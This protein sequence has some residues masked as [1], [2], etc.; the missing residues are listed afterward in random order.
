MSSH[1]LKIPIN[2]DTDRGVSKQ[3]FYGTQKVS[4]MN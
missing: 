1:E 2:P 4:N 3:I